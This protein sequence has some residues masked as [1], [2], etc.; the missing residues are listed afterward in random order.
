M[1]IK[2]VIFDLFKTLGEFKWYITDSD[3]TSLLRKRGYEV[4]PQA[5]GHAFGFVVFID[6]PRRGYDT[7][8][9][10]F[11]QIFNRLEVEVDEST[12]KE[13]ADLFRSSPFVLYDG[14]TE[15]LRLVKDAGLKTAV[16]TST[17][18]PFF[19]KGIKPIESY[20][21]FVCTGY[22][23]GYEKSNPQIYHRIL[24]RLEVNP[25]EAAVI[26]DNPTLDIANAKRLGL[27]TIQIV[28]E[29]DPS[30]Y[31]DATA[32][33]ILDAVNVLMKWV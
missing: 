24:D 14:S 25:E 9:A 11:D 23:A 3:A 18:R 5:W 15:A 20:L 4:Y 8:E 29:G 32:Q 21:D 1:S 22:E 30:E 7:H 27:R 6:Y 17:P 10:L 26:G 13:L 19:I 12:V 28:R 16:A 33:G 2:A 31:A